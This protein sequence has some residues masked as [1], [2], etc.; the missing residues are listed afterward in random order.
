VKQKSKPRPRYA[1]R[2]QLQALSEQVG[3]HSKGINAQ[4]EWIAR[5]VYSNHVLVEALKSRGLLGD[6]VIKE[7]DFAD[8]AP[9]RQ[10]VARAE[11]VSK[12][13]GFDPESRII[14]P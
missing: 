1:S 12:E 7:L 9:V 5:L 3:N 4:A 6:R 13:G 14:T 11:R 10:V 2:A 8:R